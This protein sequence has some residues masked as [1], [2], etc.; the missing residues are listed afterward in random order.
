M[1]LFFVAVVVLGRLNVM[2]VRVWN[3]FV[4]TLL[5]NMIVAEIRNHLPTVIRCDS[6]IKNLR[7]QIHVKHETL[8]S[9]G[10]HTHTQTQSNVFVIGW[11]VAIRTR[12]KIS[13][14]ANAIVTWC[15]CKNCN[16]VLNLAFMS[17]TILAALSICICNTS[18]VKTW[19]KT[20]TAKT[21]T[22][23]HTYA[24]AHS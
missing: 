13:K 22:H 5:S 14:T 2:G 21:L 7:F 18:F 15:D 6:D 23:S 10:K 11:V 24:Q 1:T 19:K 9:T 17:R 20:D 12:I 3:I 8:I 4:L 16:N